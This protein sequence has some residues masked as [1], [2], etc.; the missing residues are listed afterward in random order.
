MR[1]FLSH[2]SADKPLATQIYRAIRDQAVDVWFD[3]LEMRAIETVVRSGNDWLVRGNLAPGE[4]VVIT[5]FPEI[6]Q[7]VLVAVK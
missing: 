7:G 4:R 2:S 6:G 3:R 5:R 1:A